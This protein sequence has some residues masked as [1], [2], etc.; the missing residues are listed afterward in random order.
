[1][2]IIS[3]ANTLSVTSELVFTAVNGHAD[4]L[5]SV[6]VHNNDATILVYVGGSDVSTANG[7]PVAAGTA[8][9]LNLIQGDAVYAVAASGTP[10]I[11]VLSTRV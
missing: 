10:E 5:E 3:S 1:M 6:T 7:L 2:A 11:R 9:T 8:I 4:A